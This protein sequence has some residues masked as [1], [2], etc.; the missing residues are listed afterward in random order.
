MWD[1]RFRSRVLGAGAAVWGFRCSYVAFRMQ[2]QLC[3]VL[4]ADR[5]KLQPNRKRQPK[6]QFKILSLS[7][8]HYCHVG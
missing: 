5:G 2:V 7:V 3:E 6:N 4:G 8:N 1:F